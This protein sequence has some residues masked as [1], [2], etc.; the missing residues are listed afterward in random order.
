MYGF[1]NETSLSPQATR[2]SSPAASHREETR[3]R[4]FMK[5][6]GRKQVKEPMRPLVIQDTPQQSQKRKFQIKEGVQQQSIGETVHRRVIRSQLAREKGK[7]MITE[8]SPA[9]KG[10]LN[11]F[12]QA[13]DIEE[14][15]MVRADL[16]EASKG[17]TK[18]AKTSKKLKFDDQASEFV[19]KPR[20]LVTRLSKEIQEA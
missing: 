7:I 12:L 15:P 14:S 20:R 1:K 11:D 8:G 16:M 3:S 9:S 6:K 18:K 5:L 10:S 4:R 2:I 19:F 17:K 13:I